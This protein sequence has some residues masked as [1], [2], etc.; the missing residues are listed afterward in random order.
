[1]VKDRPGHDWRY[2]ND[3]SRIGDDLGFAPKYGF[4]T[5]HRTTIEW[6]L[7]NEFWWRAIQ[8]GSYRRYR[9]FLL[10]ILLAISTFTG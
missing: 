6:M 9:K 3:A 1:M 8:D 4:A 10:P 7:E 5:G 2:A